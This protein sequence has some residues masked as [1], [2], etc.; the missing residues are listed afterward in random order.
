MQFFMDDCKNRRQI[1]EKVEEVSHP[2]T[3]VCQY[4]FSK[5]IYTYFHVKGSARQGDPVTI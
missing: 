1:M 2:L 3:R 5:N 4:F